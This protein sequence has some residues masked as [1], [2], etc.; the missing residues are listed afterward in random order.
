MNNPSD[1]P[2]EEWIGRRRRV[3]LSGQ[4]DVVLW[5]EDDSCANC[6]T[7]LTHFEKRLTC[8]SFCRDLAAAVRYARA[9]ISDGRVDADL[10]V[11]PSIRIQFAHL[12]NGGY[13]SYG[14]KVTPQVRSDVITRDAG[15]CQ[16]CGGPGNEVDHIEGDSNEPDNLQLLCSD[17]HRKKTQTLMVPAED[18][19][20]AL[21]LGVWAKRIF[22]AQPL[23]LADSGEWASQW[24]ALEAARDKRLDDLAETLGVS[25][26]R[27]LTK[28]QRGELLRQAHRSA[29][30]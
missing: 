5:F 24:R 6:A 8:D 27:K 22:P 2:V 7:P 10:D 14:R 12:L 11:L 18:E 19:E 23:M 17:C 15:L 26:G 25:G 30:P 21:L 20:K 4:S 1:P 9:A 28:S 3:F 16:T 29:R 13:E